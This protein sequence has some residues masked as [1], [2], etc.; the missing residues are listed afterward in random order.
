[1]NKNKRIFQDFVRHFFFFVPVYINFSSAK[2][3]LFT[4]M[5]QGISSFVF[6]FTSSLSFF[7]QHGRKYA[8]ASQR[9]YYRKN[10]NIS[11]KLSD[12]FHR[13]YPLLQTGVSRHMNCSNPFANFVFKF[14]TLKKM[15]PRLPSYLDEW[16]KYK[17]YHVIHVAR[18]RRVCVWEGAFRDI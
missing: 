10:S 14:S 12:I 3:K 18:N 16:E 7:K 6:F 11:I 5:I 8:L 15:S 17:F 9:G 13:H 2:T 1:M 4:L